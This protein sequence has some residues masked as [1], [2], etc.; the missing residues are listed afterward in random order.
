MR[1]VFM[2]T[3]LFA[4]PSLEAAVASD[5]DVV[6]VITQPDRPRGRSGTPQPPP[7]KLVAQRHG[8]EVYQP[9]SVN[10]DESIDKLISSKPDVIA[11]AAFG[12]ILRR[13]VIE[14]A[15]VAC[16]NV[17][18]SLLPKYRGAAPIPAAILNGETVTGVTIQKVAPKLDAGDILRQGSLKIEPDE[19]AGELTERLA[20]LGA[21]LLA[22]SL[23]DLK[24]GRATFV[25][26]D[27]SQATFAPMLKKS[28]GRIDWRRTAEH[29][30]RHA[31]AMTPW[32]GAF[33]FLPRAGK[34]LRITVRRAA[35]AA[36][37]G[38]SAQPGT[39]V[40]VGPDGFAVKASDGA[41]LVGELQPAGK[42][43]MTAQE[44]IRGYRLEVGERFASD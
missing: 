12:Q 32:P 25:P 13:R 39:V 40:K 6:L 37:S 35:A 30:A 5:C 29:I 21:E 23:A 38:S 11:I 20:R 3:P 24:T 15:R 17:H 33:T 44:F 1:V 27:D 19:T 41:V 34:T 43:P 7:V 26:Q 18:A 28:D 9:E 14:A 8:L 22:E 16:I 10:S 31:R 36:A 2:G 42:K 4:V